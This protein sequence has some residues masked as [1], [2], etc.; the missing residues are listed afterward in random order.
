MEA[1]WKV[2]AVMGILALFGLG[3]NAFVAWIE[4]NGH[5]RGFTALLVV[6]GTVVTLIGSLALI[7]WESTLLVVLCFVASGTPMIIGS[8]IRY[9]KTCLEQEKALR[10]AAMEA[11]NGDGDA[12]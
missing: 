1:G 11:V 5:D 2:L 4:K 6:G 9:A 7:G 3:Y 12:T 8:L 10:E